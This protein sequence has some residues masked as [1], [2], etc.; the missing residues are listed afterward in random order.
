MVVTLS[1]LGIFTQLIMVPAPLFLGFWFLVQVFSGFQMH[2]GSGGVAWWAHI[3]GFAAG[4]LMTLF[5][6]AVGGLNPPP[7]HVYDSREEMAREARF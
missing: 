2:A 4:F 1:P 5:L 7:P 3:G 6:N